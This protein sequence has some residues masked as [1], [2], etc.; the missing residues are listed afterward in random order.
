MNSCSH[1]KNVDDANALSALR[2]SCSELPDRHSLNLISLCH[3]SFS[4]V[5][6]KTL[7]YLLKVKYQKLSL[8]Y[9]PRNSGP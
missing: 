9:S 2:E 5:Q 7:L 8:L 1:D 6:T 3:I 4:G